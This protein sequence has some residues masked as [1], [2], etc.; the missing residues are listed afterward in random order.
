MANKKLFFSCSAKRTKRALQP[1]Q[2][3]GPLET[4]LRDTVSNPRAREMLQAGKVLALVKYIQSEKNCL[5]RAQLIVDVG[6]AVNTAL[7]ILGTT[8]VLPIYEIMEEDP[9]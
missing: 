6:N 7:E 3:L 2:P 1:T 9:S 4:A 5:T 8:T